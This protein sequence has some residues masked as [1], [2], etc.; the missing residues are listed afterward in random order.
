MRG[1]GL[2]HTDI[3]MSVVT[4]SESLI[5][6][7]LHLSL[8]QDFQDWMMYTLTMLSFLET[9]PFWKMITFLI[10]SWNHD[11]TIQN[12]LLSREG[13]ALLL[14][15]FSSVSFLLSHWVQFF[16]VLKAL[17][18]G[19]KGLF[20]CQSFPGIRFSITKCFDFMLLTDNLV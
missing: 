13:W 7:G 2:F 16:S 8:R 11:D 10:V 1:H 6:P 4:D 3:C 20:L 17:S 15:C 5:P 19:R 9:F 12:D 18:R 14:K